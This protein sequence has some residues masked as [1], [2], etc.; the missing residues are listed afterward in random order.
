MDRLDVMSE[1]NFLELPSQLDM[2]YAEQLK[3]ALCE[4]IQQDKEIWLDAAAVDQ[5]GSSCVQLMVA[6]SRALEAVNGRL[7]LANTPTCLSEALSDLG[8]D[9]ELQKW[10]ASDA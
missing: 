2:V 3:G 7:A 4:A 5:V 6:A 10:S 9:D 1:K 8:L